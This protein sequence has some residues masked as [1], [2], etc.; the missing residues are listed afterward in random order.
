[1]NETSR[2][3]GNGQARR[4][5]AT[6]VIKHGVSRLFLLL[7]GKLHLGEHPAKSKITTKCTTKENDRI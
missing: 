3:I 1:M 4:K 6:I 2:D 5:K 7:V